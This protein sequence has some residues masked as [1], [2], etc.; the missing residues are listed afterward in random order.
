MRSAT[1]G[2]GVTLLGLLSIGG[3]RSVHTVPIRLQLGGHSVKVRDLGEGVCEVHTTG[4]DPYVV[5]ERVEQ[6][7]DHDRL[8]V[9]AFEYICPEGVDFFEVFWGNPFHGGANVTVRDIPPAEDWAPFAANLKVK[10]DEWDESVRD[11]RI[12]FGGRSGRVI[13]VRNV[14]LRAMTPEEE[15]ALRRR[16]EEAG[17]E[18]REKAARVDAALIAPAKIPDVSNVIAATQ[19]LSDDAGTTAVSVLGRELDLV[20]QVREYA[21][22]VTPPVE[23]PPRLV[24]GEGPSPGNHTIVRVLNRYGLSEVQFLAYPPEVRGGV[25]VE[26]GEVIDGQECIVTAPI[27]DPEV[28]ELRVF[29]R[30]GNLLSRLPVSQGIRPPFVLAVGNF[31]PDR[32][33][34]EIA[35]ASHRASR[36]GLGLAIVTGG[37]RVLRDG[38]WVPDVASATISKTNNWE[39]ISPLGSAMPEGALSLAAE[40]RGD[41]ASLLAYVAGASGFHRIDPMGDRAEWVDARTPADCTA[42][43]SSSSPDRPYAATAEEPLFSSL[44]RVSPGSAALRQNVGERENLFWFNATGPFKDVPEGRYVRHSLFAHIRTDFGSP[45]AS[46][47]DVGRTDADYWAGEAY[48]DRAVSRLSTYDTDPPVCWE[49]CFTHRWFYGQ[50]QTWAAAVDEETGLPAYTLIDRENTTG[51]YGEFGQKK[52]FVSG[53]YA[54]GVR[55]I[56]CFYTYPLRLFLHEL[57]TRFRGNP[58]HFVAVEPNHEMEINAESQSTHGDYNPNMIRA[59]YR[60]LLSLYGSLEGINSVFGT[61]FTDQRFD[62][63]RG[64]GRGPWDA[65]STD[66]PY[67][68]V[69][70]RFMNY[71]IYRVVAGT[72]REA[73]LAGFPPEAIKCHQIPDHY[74]ISSLAAFSKPAQRVTP[75]DWNLNAGVGFGFTRYGVWFKREHNCVQGAHSSGFDATV[76]GE[77]QSLTPDADLARQQLEYMQTNGVSFIHCMNWPKSHDRGYN[78]ALAEALAGLVRADRPRPGMTGGTGQVRPVRREKGAY[79]IVSIGTGTEHTG[80]LKSITPEGRWDGR[81]YVVPFHAH[82]KVEPIVETPALTLGRKPLVLGPFGGVGSGSVFE[83]SFMARSKEGGGLDL[84]VF[85]HGIELPEQRLAVPVGQD[86]RHVRL[87][88]RVQIDTDSLMLQLA[89]VPGEGGRAGRG[90]VELRDVLAVRHTEQTTKLKKGVF[91]GERHRGGITFDVMGGG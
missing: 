81:V 9:L 37:G 52:S 47:P 11:F 60:Y 79:D 86:W 25:W 90:R 75:I 45:H 43:F 21:G 27:A 19:V 73:L 8:F 46:D 20:T 40:R 17:A 38:G 10:G 14:H 64:L 67:Y 44:C 18:L 88:V 87:L 68:M 74:A 34:D 65:Y 16:E 58:E 28:R 33:G 15:S 22:D 4:P 59:F 36:W 31:A 85:H 48:R 53:S 84:D 29:S 89:S 56:E 78:K 7:F 5:C 61:A 35:V 83:L 50:A 3:C 55:P 49:P 2:V 30:N 76:I 57:V 23:L 1:T 39:H 26:C 77:Y 12:D 66:N 54:P 13:K 41:S 32:P 63:P 24:V 51:T 69:W 80:L 72:Y 91:A 82:V 42:L 6:R 62:A 70:M 71:V